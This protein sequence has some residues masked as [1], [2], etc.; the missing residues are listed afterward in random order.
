MQAK[1]KDEYR[2]EGVTAGLRNYAKTEW[3]DVLPD[4]EQRVTEGYGD[5]LD[6]RNAPPEELDAVTLAPGLAVPGT[7]PVEPAASNAAKVATTTPQDAAQE[8]IAQAVVAD[9]VPNVVGDA[10]GEM[11]GRPESDA[12]LE[13]E[14]EADDA[15]AAADEYAAQ[16]KRAAAASKRASRKGTA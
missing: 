16:K 3:R 9:P 6:F 13:A 11:A 12:A 2:F 5:M 10:V 7:A 15:E 14:A 1:V 8:Q 4:W